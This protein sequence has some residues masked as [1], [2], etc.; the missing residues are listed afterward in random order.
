MSVLPADFS[1]V[2]R[3]PYVLTTLP[4][5]ALKA[6]LLLRLDATNGA[7]LPIFGSGAS[8]PST[9]V[10]GT[11][12]NLYGV[13]LS[14]VTEA[15]DPVYS[16]LPDYAGQPHIKRLS[17]AVCVP[18]R[19]LIVFPINKANGELDYAQAVASNIGRPVGIY[20]R[21]VPINIGGTNYW[22]DV[23]GHVGGTET[24]GFVIG[25]TRDR[26][27]IVRIVRN[28]WAELA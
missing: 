22:L 12:S 17:V 19:E 11:V 18:H 13:S 25:I 3:L 27:L 15:N 20:Y 5:A 16:G 2:R 14:G 4:E 8:R 21:N 6:G 9:D 23:G 7:V 26:R 28:K 1:E 24:G 10:L